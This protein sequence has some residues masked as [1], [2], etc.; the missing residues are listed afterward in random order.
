MARW[1]GGLV[2]CWPGDLLTWW[3]GGLVARWPVTCWPG[4]LVARCT[5]AR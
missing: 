3:R 5:V 1:R 2:A 4:D